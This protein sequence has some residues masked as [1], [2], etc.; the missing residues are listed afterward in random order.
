[1][2]V[3]IWL[4]L[5]VVV[6][7]GPLAVIL[8]ARKFHNLSTGMADLAGDGFLYFFT[9][10]LAAGVISDTLKATRKEGLCAPGAPGVL[11]AHGCIN[12]DF[13]IA[14]VLV[15]TTV[16]AMTLLA[17]GLALVKRFSAE[18]GD[19]QAA[20]ITS[21]WFASVGIILT[22]IVRHLGDLW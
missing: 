16:A 19:G 6:A 17:Y 15:G 22:I 14:V 10:V 20:T 2:D 12:F 7:L 18:P 11:G 13:V 9:V 1:M 3:A 8:V 5:N 21:L 4:F